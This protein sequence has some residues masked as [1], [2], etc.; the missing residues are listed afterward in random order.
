MDL[1]AVRRRGRRRRGEPVGAAAREGRADHRRRRGR[2]GLR[3]RHGGAAPGCEAGQHHAG[4]VQR[5]AGGAGFPHRFRH[6]QAARGLRPP[7]PDRNVH[8]HPGLRLAGTDDRR[9]PRQPLRSILA[10]LRA[11]LAAGRRRAVR[12][13]QP[14][15]HHPRPPPAPAALGPAAQAQS[16][17][18]PGRGARGGHGETPGTPL[19][20]VR[21]IRLRRPQGAHRGRTAPATGPPPTRL[22]A[23][24]VPGATRLPPTLADAP[25]TSHA[26]A[27]DSAATGSDAGPSSAGSATPS[28]GCDSGPAERAAGSAGSSATACHACTAVAGSA[29]SWTDT[30]SAERISAW[31]RPACCRAAVGCP[32]VTAAGSAA[33]CADA[34]AA[35]RVSAWSGSACGGAAVGCPS[36]AIAGSASCIDVVAAQCIAA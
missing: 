19:P 14:R 36:V 8:G 20:L 16:E 6:C 29:T 21:R 7:H 27:A 35:E 10:G 30:G 28:S 15:R 3:A 2:T 11:V 24:A 1:H 26:T 12:R 18:R 13:R 31:S 5:R 25:G 32:G 9:A 33:T 17:S 23:P 22:R 4:Q 34:G